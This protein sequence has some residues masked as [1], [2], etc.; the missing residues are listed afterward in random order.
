VF[1]D[2]QEA[3][4][5]RAAQRGEI[6]IALLLIDHG[7]NLGTAGWI[8]MVGPPC[9]LKTAVDLAAEN[10]KAGVAKFIAED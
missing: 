7:A 8:A 9:T 3:P 6:W 4:L 2:K 5:Y 1:N 10:G